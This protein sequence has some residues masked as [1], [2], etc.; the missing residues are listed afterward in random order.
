MAIKDGLGTRRVEIVPEPEMT[1]VSAA[2]IAGDALG[3]NQDP[4]VAAG[5]TS[6]S[7]IG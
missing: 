7:R 1:S 4:S 2:L 6:P 3:W 5:Y